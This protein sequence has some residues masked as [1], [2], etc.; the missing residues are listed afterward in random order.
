MCFEH[1]VRLDIYG[2]MTFKT[3]LAAL[4]N[5][6]TSQIV[7]AQD[8]SASGQKC[9]LRGTVDMLDDM[10]NTLEQKHWYECLLETRPTRIFLD[11]ESKTSID[12][13]EIVDIC[14]KAIR[15]KYDIEP[16]MEVLDSSS[17]KKY[18]WHVLCTNLY[19]KNIFHVGAFVRRLVLL[20]S[21]HPGRHGIDTAVYTRNRM[22]RVA[23]SSK[24]GSKRVLKHPSA[25]WFD[26]LVQ[27]VNVPF[28]ECTE[29]DE[30]TPSSTSQH[31]D[32]MFVFEDG[33]WKRTRHLKRKTMASASTNCPMLTPVLDWLDRH[34]TAQTCRHNM[35]LTE[36]G[37]YR[38]STRSKKCAI[39]GRTHKGNNIWFN[40]DLN[41]RTV[42]QRC[43]DE[44][45]RTHARPVAV[46]VEQW[47]KW[48]RSWC[49]VIHAPRN[50]KTL[51]NMSR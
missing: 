37:H 41:R 40:I 51:F 13:D 25:K 22:F 32:N 15:I 19:L 39:A 26:L 16:V 21:D 17:E 5:L 20:M 30:S 35:S 10:Y 1:Q 2:S 38:V 8:V 34:L 43:Y 36:S 31:P 47:S 9:F 42:Y 50:E 29:I 48:N 12:I 4:T 33:H 18:S 11:V 27:S 7:V 24:F 44:E 3:L 14:K 49:E 46:P 23:G 6:P 28:K 45:C